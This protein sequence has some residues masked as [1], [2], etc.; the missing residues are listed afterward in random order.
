MGEKEDSIS[1]TILRWGARKR[2]RMGADS[3]LSFRVYTAKMMLSLFFILLDGIFIPSG[4]EAAGLL[5]T[6]F[7]IPI[8][9][10]LLVAVAVELKVL[11]L[12]R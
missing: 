12:F 5:T 2:I 11:S 4:F 1:E 3:K 7:A 10:A 6:E 8:A 9:V